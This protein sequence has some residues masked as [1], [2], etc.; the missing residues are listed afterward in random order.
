M[1]KVIAVV[2]MLVMAFALA[3]CAPAELSVTNDNEGVHAVAKNG[4][5]GASAGQITVEPGYGLCINHIV[6]RGTF[7][8]KA[9]DQLGKVV[10]DEDI[11]DNI[12][13]FIEAN[14]D[15][16]IEISAKGADGTVD[17]IAYDIEAQAQ[18]DTALPDFL[19]SEG[20]KS[21]SSDASTSIA[22]PWTDVK[23][24]AEA[25]EGAGVGTFELPEAG[26]EIGGGRVDLVEFRYMDLLAE[27]DG[28]AG[29]AELVVRKGVNRPDHA[30]GYDTADVSGDYTAYAHEWEIEA[31][32]WKVTCFGNE[33]GKAMKAIWQ[34][35]NFSYSIMV[36]G[37]GELHDTYGLGSDDIAT[38]VGTIA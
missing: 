4:V 21:S 10:F 16:D 23:T 25:A 37:Q 20:A 15:F 7:H 13:D 12:A 28:Y 17:I 26:M 3:A 24:A 30:V 8:V 22:N 34:S 9:T 5:D 14:G 18:A 6:N 29:T 2:T 1:K 33:E 27:A 36:R 35:D 31:A 32:G 38:L 11:S 19:K